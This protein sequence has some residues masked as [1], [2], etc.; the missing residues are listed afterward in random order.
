LKIGYNFIIRQE[1]MTM[2]KRLIN[3]IIT[4]F[5]SASFMTTAHADVVIENDF[6]QRNRDRTVS[7]ANPD[8]GGRWGG[9]MFMVNSPSGSVAP[10]INPGSSESMQD[11]VEMVDGVPVYEELTFNNGDIISLTAAYRHNGRY[12][13][14]MT[15][16]H[17][18]SPSGWIPMDELLAVYTGGE[19]MGENSDKF[20]RYT[21]SFDTVKEAEVLVFWQWPGSDRE[22]RVI[23]NIFTEEQII[24]M[25]RITN[26]YK[27]SEGREWVRAWVSEGWNEGYGGWICLVDPANTGNIPAFHPAPAPRIWVSEG[28]YE[29]FPYAVATGVIVGGTAVIIAGFIMFASRK[30]QKA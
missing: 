22:K 7:V 1:E 8:W 25:V 28:E 3:I 11:F 27:D 13:G 2:I 23:D 24:D 5:L 29:D 20:Y 17:R 15:Y 21:G 19:F 26:T 18:Y 4:I 14:L 6:F 10:K 9:N 12:W 30:R 16:S